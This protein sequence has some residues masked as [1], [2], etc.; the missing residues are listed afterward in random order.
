MSKRQWDRLAALGGVAFV[1]LYAVG[2]LLPGEPP[3]VEDSAFGGFL[4][5]VAW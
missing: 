1:V 3:K 4:S 5:F 2:T